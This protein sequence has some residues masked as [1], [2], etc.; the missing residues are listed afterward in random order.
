MPV[1][2][3]QLSPNFRPT[4]AFPSWNLQPL[5]SNFGT[6]STENNRAEPANVAQPLN[7]ALFY[8]LVIFFPGTSTPGDGRDIPSGITLLYTGTFPQSWGNTF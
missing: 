5:R 3:Q 6:Q 1:T 2:A 7:N 4:L 8:A